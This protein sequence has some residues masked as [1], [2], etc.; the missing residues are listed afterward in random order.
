MVTEV[1][2]SAGTS[3]TQYNEGSI[4]VR[5]GVKYTVDVEVLR[6]DLGG[7]GER[8]EDILLRPDQGIQGADQVSIGGCNPDGGDQDCTFFNCPITSATVVSQ[9]LKL[10]LEM[11]LLWYLN[12]MIGRIA[13][14][15]KFTLNTVVNWRQS[16]NEWNLSLI[17]LF[18]K[19]LEEFVK[20]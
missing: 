6:N 11:L 8:V 3:A 18:N 4:T 12:I 16:S 9:G 17:W 1:I 7:S 10:W 13:H 15:Q 19:N 14:L 20:P 5:P 2:Y